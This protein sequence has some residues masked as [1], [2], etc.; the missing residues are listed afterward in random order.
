MHDLVAHE[1]VEG[2]ENLRQETDDF[3]LWEGAFVSQFG[4]HVSA[5]A[6]FEH[7]VVVMGGLLQGVQLDDVRVV[8]SF[9]HFD[10]AFQQF[11]EFAW[12]IGRIPLIMSRRMDLMATV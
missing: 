9:Q 6:V 7:E 3:D 2:V 1:G 11:I 12:V 10:F 5:I 8:A 4:E